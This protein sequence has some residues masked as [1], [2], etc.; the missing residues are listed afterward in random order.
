MF[1]EKLTNSLVR[2]A[3]GTHPSAIQEVLGVLE[4]VEANMLST[5]ISRYLL[6]AKLQ[7]LVLM[8]TKLIGIGLAAK[9]RWATTWAFIMCAFMLFEMWLSRPEAG[10]EPILRD[11]MRWICIVVPAFLVL[12][13]TPSEYARAAFS[14]PSVAYAMTNLISRG[15]A[16]EKRLAIVQQHVKTLEARCS[17]RVRTHK[18]VVGIAW[19]VWSFFLLKGS[20]L[21]VEGKLPLPESIFATAGAFYAVVG[22]YLLASGYEAA[23]ARV[24]RSIEIAAAELLLIQQE[25]CEDKAFHAEGTSAASRRLP[26]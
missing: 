6:L 4:D 21:M 8:P 1:T 16:T 24:F 3:P 10:L 5:R 2:P 18:W 7:R 14:E 22:F 12:F 25:L 19:A 20:D 13:P 26:G 15:L 9:L 23:L 17:A 11:A